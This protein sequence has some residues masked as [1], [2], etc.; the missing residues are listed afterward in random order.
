ML[1]QYFDTVELTFE[2]VKL[3][4]KQL[5]REFYGETPQEFLK[6]VVYETKVTDT[7]I[8]MKIDKLSENDKKNFY[9][10]DWRE[11]K[12]N[13]YKWINSRTGNIF[14][15]DGNEE[16]SEVS[17]KKPHPF[18]EYIC[19]DIEKDYPEIYEDLMIQLCYQKDD[20]GK[21]YERIYNLFT[22]KYRDIWKE[23]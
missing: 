21:D 19:K 6:A 16:T 2:E 13:V 10:D 7:I 15:I 11:I 14:I 23:M 17:K 22:I 9:W 8:I 1:S 5:D 12:P 4:I 3:R 20:T 18:F